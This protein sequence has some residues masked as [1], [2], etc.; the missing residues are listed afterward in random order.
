M[1]LHIP[2]SSRVIPAED[3]AR[4]CL[5]DTE[6]DQELLMMTDAW[7]G[8]LFPEIAF[9]LRR[10]IFPVSRLVCD[11]ERFV[12][13]EDEPMSRM[14]MG[15]VYTHTSHGLRLREKLWPG[16]RER[17]LDRWYRPHHALLTLAVNDSLNRF[18]RALVVDCH[19]F[20]SKPLPYEQFQAQE[21]PDICIGTESFHTPADLLETVI[22]AVRR[23]GWTAHVNSPFPGV[24]VPIS[25]FRRDGRVRALM[26]E[27]NRALYMDES[28]GD[29][30]PRFA[31]VRDGLGRVLHS[32]CE[33]A[34]PHPS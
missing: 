11:P 8:E 26:I 3:R 27:V 16:E 33:R 28:T 20:P 6:L 15:A 7:T 4:L 18:G 25:H 10:V 2:H 12:C 22:A 31:L 14:G 9:E 24:L 17:V 19:S 32:L 30:S 29:R 23:E 13:D 34:D 21:R 5:P 1:I